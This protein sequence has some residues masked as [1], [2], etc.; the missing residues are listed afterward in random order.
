MLHKL[1][2]NKFSTNSGS[3]NV[4]YAFLAINAMCIGTDWVL[5]YSYLNCIVTS[6][7]HIKF[8]YFRSKWDRKHS[9]NISNF[10]YLI[11]HK[12]KLKVFWDGTK[13]I[14]WLFENIISFEMK[15]S[16]NQKFLL[17]CYNLIREMQSLVSKLKKLGFSYDFQCRPISIS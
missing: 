17:K 14:S 16:N 12:K 9:R 2:Q 7:Q 3:A 5:W 8:T 13:D 1:S 15:F 4:L 6:K 10:R 11:S